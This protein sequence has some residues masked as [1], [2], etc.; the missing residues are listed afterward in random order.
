MATDTTMTTPSSPPGAV[1]W[2]RRPWIAPLAI[3]TAIF[4]ATALPRYV[5]LDPSR[6]LMVA[7]DVDDRG[8]AYYPALVTH[9][10]FGSVMLSAAVLQLW[11]WLRI[12]HPRVHRWSG[13]VYV[14]TAIPTGL[15]A[16]VTAQYPTAGPNQQLANTFL[17]VLLVTFTLLGYR[18][19]RQRRF[20][21]H[22]QWMIR[23]TA[24]A[25]SIVANRFWGVVLV[26]IFAPSFD[27]DV[28]SS[29]E[30]LSAAGA[31]AWVSWVVNLLFAEWWIHKYP[32]IRDRA[33]ARK[34][35]AAAV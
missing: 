20:A 2:W 13:R 16:L 15:A 17:A 6:A 28:A 11:P 3:I 32:K 7:G 29:P 14:M 8:P 21:D 26:I 24:L 9:I 10:F 5:G 1:R 34:V 22:R 27:G 30:A 31:S 23:S 19:V 25:F 33:R 12:N 35:Q 18:A 4:L